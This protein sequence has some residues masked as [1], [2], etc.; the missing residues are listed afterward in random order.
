ME[1]MEF[2]STHPAQRDGRSLT[3]R[4]EGVALA[5]GARTFSK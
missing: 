1:I 4:I 3:N 5:E 2:A